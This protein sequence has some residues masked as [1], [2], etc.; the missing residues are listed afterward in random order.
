MDQTYLRHAELIFA[1]SS[2]FLPLFLGIIHASS[3]K[4]NKEDM[5]LHY[6]LIIGV[7]IQG[8][9]T[10][11]TQSFFP[12]LVVSVTDWPYTPYLIELGFANIS[13][14]LLALISIGMGRC[15]KVAAV[16]G[17]SLFYLMTAARHL[18]EIQHI[19]LNDGNM[20]GFLFI[21]LLMPITLLILIY[22]TRKKS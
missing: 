17:F 1:L 6:Y 22:L 18:F 2:Y 8:F 14:S 11:I 9:I 3:A 20:G 13:Y 4:K 5:I 16:I 21:D 10:G 19:G 12:S 7:G 15:W